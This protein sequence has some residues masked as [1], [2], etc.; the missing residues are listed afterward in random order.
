MNAKR[1]T[2][3]FG[4]FLTL[5]SASLLLAGCDEDDRDTSPILPGQV[6]VLNVSFSPETV[7]Q[8]YNDT[9]RYIVTVDESNGVGATITSM[10]IERIDADGQSFD[11]DNYNEEGVARIFGTSYISSMGRL[12]SDVTHE[13]YSCAQERWLL[14]FTDDFG[15]SREASGLVTFV[16]RE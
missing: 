3:L 5:C 7:Y 6:A 11:S 2:Y 14:R 10:K 4:F 15:N 13:C 9:Y 12:Q 1:Q 16:D 8:G